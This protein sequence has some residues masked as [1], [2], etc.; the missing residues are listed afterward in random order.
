MV[1]AVSLAVAI[2]IGIGL[3]VFPPTADDLHLSWPW[4]KWLAWGQS[5]DWDGA[6]DFA[7]WFFNNENRRLANFV[8]LA[9]SALPRWVGGM[10][11]GLAIG[12]IIYKGS[13]LA[14][15]GRRPLAFAIWTAAIVMGLPWYDQLYLIDF[16][17]NYTWAAAIM[18]AFT[19]YLLKQDCG[20]HVNTIAMFAL[21]L[22][23]GAWHEGFGVPCLLA[24]I[25]LPIM[26]R[27]FRTKVTLT[28]IAGL[29]I[30]SAYLIITPVMKR[31]LMQEDGTIVHYFYSKIALYVY[32]Y[33]AVGV[34]YFV[35]LAVVLLSRRCKL[36]R[37]PL[38]AFA[39]VVVAASWVITYVTN[40]GPRAFTPGLTFGL[41]G[42]VTCGTALALHRERWRRV[43][44]TIAAL[45]YVFL[46]A[47]LV[48]V[49]IICARIQ[50][51]YRQTI[52]AWRDN[53]AVTAFVPMTSRN[54]V[55]WLCVWKP[56]YNLFSH[57]GPV[58]AISRYYFDADRPLLA[59]PEQL[60]SYTPRKA[61]PIPGEAR[62]TAFKGYIVGP[63]LGP[64]AQLLDMRDSYGW[65]EKT[66]IYYCVPFRS[67]ADNQV[68]AWY[69]PEHTD[70]DITLSSIP[71][72]MHPIGY[73]VEEWQQ[74]DPEAKLKHLTR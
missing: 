21:A 3:S 53:P 28:A 2:L 11:S 73:T 31:L 50:C 70:I 20:K 46:T 39:S 43:S 13:Q 17:L 58:K 57:V 30:G 12:Y 63:W 19:G 44:V 40:P 24:T 15:L 66:R 42:I 33:L 5:R 64:Y 9:L 41:L 51:E 25:A 38:W 69:H 47:H 72:Y 61:T 37:M 6:R 45:I 26:W 27:R 14:D 67:R 16:Q 10:L 52:Q 34:I 56:H 22:L 74:N 36:T 23:M 7:V 29:A 65:G 1:P 60:A 48:Y 59:V 71:E 62:V 68:Y 32:P 54:D 8:M 4:R 18:L 49:D 35:A 55:S